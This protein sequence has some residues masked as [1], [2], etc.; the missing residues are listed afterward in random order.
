MRILRLNII[1]SLV[2]DTISVAPILAELRRAVEDA[3]L[4]E[5]EPTSKRRLYLLAVRTLVS[6]LMLLGRASACEINTVF[7]YRV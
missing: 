6:Q 4:E 5:V 2:G 3:P 7:R 1:K